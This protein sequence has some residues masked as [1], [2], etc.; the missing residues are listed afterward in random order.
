LP[1]DPVIVRRK[2]EHDRQNGWI[3]SFFGERPH[4]LSSHV[5]VRR[6]LAEI[7]DRRTT[8][9]LA[10]LIAEPT[11]AAPGSGVPRQATAERTFT[12]KM[13]LRRH[14]ATLSVLGP[15]QRQARETG[16]AT[17]ACRELP[18]PAPPSP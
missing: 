5:P 7:Q 10:R 13:V 9:P 2:S 15:G 18:Y 17:P 14:L 11:V 4:F 16:T 6:G 1:G 8:S 12:T 3:V